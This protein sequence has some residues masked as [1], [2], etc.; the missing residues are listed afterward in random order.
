MVHAVQPRQLCR[1]EGAHVVSWVPQEAHHDGENVSLFQIRLARCIISTSCI[2]HD[3]KDEGSNVI[4]A[5]KY[6]HRCCREKSRQTKAAAYPERSRLLDRPK[7]HRRGYAAVAVERGVSARLK[8]DQ[9]I[10][11][12]GRQHSSA[13]PVTL[14]SAYSCT[15]AVR[16]TSRSISPRTAEKISQVLNCC[17]LGCQAACHS[18]R[19]KRWSASDV[20]TRLRSSK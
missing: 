13:T 8:S 19:W 5:C 11:S 9:I 14:T 4:Q 3:H 2:S 20:A 10:P 16:G 1:E 15:L 12:I 7:Q 17:S 18:P 6:Q